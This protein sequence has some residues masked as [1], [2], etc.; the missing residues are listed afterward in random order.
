MNKRALNY[1]SHPE[2]SMWVSANAGSGKTQ[3]LITRVAR[4]LL[5]GAQPEKILCL[6]KKIELSVFVIN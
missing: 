4:I 6:T 5:Q 1:V 3:N 2:N